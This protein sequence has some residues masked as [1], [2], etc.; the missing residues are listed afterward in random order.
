MVSA[1]DDEKSIAGV[2]PVDGIED[3]VIYLRTH[4]IDLWKGNDDPK[5]KKVVKKMEEEREAFCW[6]VDNFELPKECRDSRF[7]VKGWQHP[8]LVALSGQ[9][10]PSMHLAG[11]IQDFRYLGSCETVFHT[12]EWV[13]AA[14]IARDLKDPAGVA[15]NN[16]KAQSVGSSLG[17]IKAEIAKGTDFGFTAESKTVNGVLRWSI[18]YH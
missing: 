11:M 9:G 4:R 18:N 3:K 17:Y 10:A 7:G 14:Q 5:A 1:N 8:S 6:F 13:T 16:L 2:P 12:G 15:G